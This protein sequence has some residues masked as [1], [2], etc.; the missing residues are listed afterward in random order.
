MIPDS[1][2]LTCRS[3]LK[4][5]LSLLTWSMLAAC[6]VGPGT[7]V[8]CARAGSEQGL[9]LIWALIFGTI[10]AY[11]LQEGSA[12]LTIS[13]GRSL[14][15]CLRIKYEN[16]YR[17]YNVAVICWV[18]TIAVFLGNTM[19]ECNNWAGG[20]S[21]IYA[22]PS[23]E[24]SDAL[25][26]GCCIGYGVVVYALLYWDKT[27]WLSVG[28]G[29]ILMAMVLLFLIVVSKMGLDAERFGWGLI[30]NMPEGSANL[31]LS[32]VG[33]TSIGFNLFL[34]SSIAE[35]KKLGPS[36]RGIAFSVF[37]AF[38]VSVLIMIVGDGVTSDVEGNFTIDNLAELIEETVG[39]VGLWIFALGFIAAALSSMLTVPLGAAITADS[40]FTIK[41][42]TEASLGETNPVAKPDMLELETPKPLDQDL[43][44]SSTAIMVKEEMNQTLPR[45]IYQGIMIVIVLIAVIVISADF[46]T[47]DVIQVAQVFNGCLLPFFAICLLLC[48][49]DEQFMEK[50]PQKWWSNIFLVLAVTITL[51]LALNVFIQNIF[52]SLIS[53]P[54][55]KFGIAGGLAPTVIVLLCVSTSL[56]K[57]LLRSFKSRS[58]TYELGL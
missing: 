48:L 16:T 17:L 53:D 51:F 36:Q 54:A 52:G 9:N 44:K 7:V 38:V 1:M 10:L 57:D 5:V 24:N 3:V 8:T 28:L 32:L 22:L 49:N 4:E 12:R 2:H 33:T 31:L 21:A 46:P 27:E 6:T 42:D 20:M 56:G 50:A 34:G 55:I 41:R 35:G 26:I 47:E 19:Y 29:I 43:S 58:Q 18:V 37:S 15:Q 11:T 14:G 23:A 39:L 13:S 45:W 25:R 40:L 30:P